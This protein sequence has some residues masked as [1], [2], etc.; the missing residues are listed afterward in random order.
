MRGGPLSVLFI[1][2]VASAGLAVGVGRPLK[3]GRPGSDGSL[4]LIEPAN[5]HIKFGDVI[6][7]Q[8]TAGT[9]VWCTSTGDPS[10]A[11]PFGDQVRFRA[12]AD[13][14]RTD[15]L[16]FTPTAMQW[17]HPLFDL[18]SA[19]VV[20]AAE[21]DSYG[22][23]PGPFTMR[24]YLF[25]DHGALPV[26]SI[27]AKEE[28]LFGEDDGLLVAGNGILHIPQ[29]VIDS[30]TND[31]RW[32]KY[33]G[34]YHGRGKEWERKARMQVIDVKGDELFQ[35]E[36]ALRNNGQMTRGFPQH[37]LRVIMDEPMDAALFSGEG[38][39]TKA[40]VLRAAGNDQVKA[41]LRDAY[42]H[43]LCEGL[44]FMTSRA[45]TSVVYINGAYQGVYH[46]RQ[47]LDEDELARRL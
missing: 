8:A 12:N 22:A 34:N 31:P 3:M 24:T 16:L 45:L 42:Q 7:V 10:Q 46:L 11:Q 40:M 18:P 20:S 23:T 6:S 43:A 28:D 1:A 44:P 35:G 15:H 21:S 25:A 13:H 37:A 47:R 2:V 29:P 5:A 26:I 36:V 19:M 38:R 39:G 32:W 33:P 4:P 9:G 27:S 41:V 17:R 14:R 30:Y